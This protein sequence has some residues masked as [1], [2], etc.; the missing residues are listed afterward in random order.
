M[1]T[2]E[3]VTF[4][5]ASG[6]QL[7]GILTTPALPSALSGS[8]APFPLGRCVVL[9]H[10]GMANKNS[11]SHPLIAKGLANE[12]GYRVFRYDATG[13]GESVP[14]TGSG[15]EQAR[16]MMSGFWDDVDDLASTVRM[17]E[18]RDLPVE[19]VMGH[20]RGGQVVHMFAAR[21]PQLGVPR[22]IAANMRWD[23]S[24]WRRQW[25]TNVARDGHWTLR[26]KNRG[27]DVTHTVSQSDV[28]VYANVPME[29][30]C[31]KIEARVLNV[32]GVLEHGAKSGQA[33]YDVGALM[34]ADGV[35]PFTDIEG[36][37]NCIRYHELRFLCGAGHFYREEGAAEALWDAVKAWLLVPSSSQSP[38]PNAAATRL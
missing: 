33:S 15:S 21:Y 30:E 23:L 20:S 17:L 12:L 1:S 9:V 3:K 11:F 34:T 32:Y 38:Q 2:E 10:G 16:N 37:A 7:V 4:E 25:E 36:P 22:I 29:A 26:W 5:G 31:R 24:Y 14:I 27:S 8:S 19:A 13:N 18:M 6:N 35:V 28:E